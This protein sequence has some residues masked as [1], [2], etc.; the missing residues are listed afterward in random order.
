MSEQE[1]KPA[2]G[3]RWRYGTR[4]SV[5]EI[6]DGPASAGFALAR[7]VGTT[8]DQLIGHPVEIRLAGLGTTWTQ[9]NP[10]HTLEG[11]PSDA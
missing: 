3:T 11:S 8:S 10:G 4:G 6:V 7:G 1:S 9:V 5:Y 2:V